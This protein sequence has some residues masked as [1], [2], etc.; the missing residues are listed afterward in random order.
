MIFDDV[1]MDAGELTAERFCILNSE[2][3][4]SQCCVQYR[5]KFLKI[6]ALPRENAFSAFALVVALTGSCEH[7]VGD[8]DNGRRGI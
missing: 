3:S 2:M 8:F 7:I 4:A 5:G 1:D 6:V